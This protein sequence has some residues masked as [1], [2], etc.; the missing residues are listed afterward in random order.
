MIQVNTLNYTSNLLVDKNECLL[1][2]WKLK[3][4]AHL[5]ICIT[6]MQS[7][8]VILLTKLSKTSQQKIANLGLM[9]VIT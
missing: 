9:V 3:N 4:E 2:S 5:S 7:A 6:I 8:P 1:R